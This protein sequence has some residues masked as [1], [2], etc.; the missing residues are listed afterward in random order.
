VSTPAGSLLPY[1]SVAYFFVRVDWRTVSDYVGDEGQRGTKLDALTPGTPQYQVIYTLLQEASG[2]VE[3]ACL[4]G[5][6][7]SAADLGILTGNSQQL[8]AG[9]VAD[10]CLGKVLDRRPDLTEEVPYRVRRAGDVL[11]ALS[12]GERIFALQEVADA[13]LAAHAIDTPQ[14]AINRKLPSTVLSR[15]FGRRLNTT[16]QP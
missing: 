4:K 12:G 10:L 1:C 11:E 15:Y 5:E 14:T 13:G 6:R 2:E 8:L 16:P 3:A 7:Y 9:L